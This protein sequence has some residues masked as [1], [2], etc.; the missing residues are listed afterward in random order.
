MNRVIYGKGKGSILLHV[1]LCR[2]E[3]IEVLR[4]AFLPER[5]SGASEQVLTPRDDLDANGYTVKPLGHG[6]YLV[7]I[8]HDG[9]RGITVSGQEPRAERMAERAGAHRTAGSRED[10]ASSGLQARYTEEPGATAT[11]NFTGNRVRLLGQARPD[12]GLAEI[13][14]RRCQAAAWA[15]IAGD[16]RRTRSHEPAACSTSG[17]VWR[18]AAHV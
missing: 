3:T 1:R 14:P 18:T 6:D 13:V 9:I 17:M 12:G 10:S 8:R 11:L 5:I 7:S 4:L 2:A 15:S 16:R